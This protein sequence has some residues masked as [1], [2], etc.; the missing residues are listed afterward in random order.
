MNGNNFQ[1]WLNDSLQ[2]EK[3]MVFQPL[4]CLF[5]ARAKFLSSHLYFCGWFSQRFFS[6][7]SRTSV[8]IIVIIVAP[9][10]DVG[11][12]QKA[13]FVI[14]QVLREASLTVMCHFRTLPFHTAFLLSHLLVH[15]YVSH[16]FLTVKTLSLTSANNSLEWRGSI[17]IAK[18]LGSDCQTLRDKKQREVRLMCE[19]FNN[20][21][22]EKTLTASSVHPVKFKNLGH[23]WMRFSPPLST[24][25]CA[26]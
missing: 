19:T 5:I 12:L 16:I 17:A 1:N 20:D 21:I 7:P 3:E 25:V 18:G 14:V 2:K 15:F 4:F 6:E 10:V 13:H 9:I 24:F 8:E 22:D 23:C 26:V 11:V